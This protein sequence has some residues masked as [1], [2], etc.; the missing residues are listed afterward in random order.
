M[1]QDRIRDDEG[2][3]LFGELVGTVIV[4][5]IGHEHRQAVGAMPGADEMIRGGL[6]R[7]IGRVRVVSRGLGEGPVRAETPKHLVGGDMQKTKSI[8]AGTRQPLKII[9]RGLQQ[10]IGT[11]YI[12][13]DEGGWFADGAVDMRLGRQMHHGIGLL[14]GKDIVN[15]VAIADVKPVELVL[16]VRCNGGE[17]ARIGGVGK[18]VDIDHPAAGG[19]QMPANRRADEAGTPCDETLHVPSPIGQNVSAIRQGLP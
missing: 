7:R 15:S 1:P 3:E 17:S 10:L 16:R 2:N 18:L 14:P 19:D 11:E 9:A 5:A 8:G 4:A 12:G 13:G 6:A